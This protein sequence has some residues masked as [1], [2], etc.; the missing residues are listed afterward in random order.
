MTLE[1]YFKNRIYQ[2]TWETTHYMASALD[3]QTI[4]RYFNSSY[5]RVSSLNRGETGH[6]FPYSSVDRYG[7]LIIPESLGFISAQEAETDAA[8]LVQNS[9][10]LK[11]VRDGVAS[12]FFHP[13]LEREHL[14]RVLDGIKAN[15]YRFRSINDYDC[16][17]QM[18]DMLV[19]TYSDTVHLPVHGRY[20]HRFLMDSDGRVSSESYSEK[21][22]DTNVTDPGVVPPD[23]I[24]VMEGVS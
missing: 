23:A 10:R 6:T 4:A 20:L 8:T 11:V 16:R 9:L 1:E 7:R 24:L 12:F 15:G 19:Q 17:V 3:Y 22:L 13:F 21:P 18:D 2:V 14:T 5:E